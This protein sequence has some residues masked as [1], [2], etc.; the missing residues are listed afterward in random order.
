MNN[1]SLG[2]PSPRY[3]HR[4]E[5]LVEEARRLHLAARASKAAKREA[6][7]RRAEAR[8]GSATAR[9]IG[10][11]STPARAGQIATPRREQGAPSPRSLRRSVPAWRSAAAIMGS[12]LV[13]MGVRLERLA[14]APAQRSRV[15]AS[16]D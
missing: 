11:P 1:E 14:S 2:Y 3:W 15:E 12:S 7:A 13:A 8:A 5:E 10:A 4:Q 16:R 6:A 9:V